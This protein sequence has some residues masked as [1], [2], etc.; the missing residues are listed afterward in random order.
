VSL[1]T[2]GTNALG[3]F[4]VRRIMRWQKNC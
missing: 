1:S 4:A 3:Y 2:P